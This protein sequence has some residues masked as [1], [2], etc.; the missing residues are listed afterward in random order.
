MRED[1]KRSYIRKISLNNKHEIETQLKGQR[2]ELCGEWVWIYYDLHSERD[3]WELNFFF[4]RFSVGKDSD[5]KRF[6]KYVERYKTLKRYKVIKRY[7]TKIG[8]INF[9]GGNPILKVLPN[10][11]LGSTDQIT[12][13]YNQWVVYDNSLIR[14]LN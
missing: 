7:K 14:L 13:E 2:W 10:N 11:D 9:R 12:T 1:L 6:C 4:I 5:V 3:C 8:Q